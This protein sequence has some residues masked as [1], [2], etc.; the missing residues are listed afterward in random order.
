MRIFVNVEGI[1]K[2]YGNASDDLIAAARALGQV[3]DVSTFTR[4]GIHSTIANLPPGESALLVGG[5]DLIPTFVLTNPTAHVEGAHGD[6][7][8]PSD[9]P[10]GGTPGNGP[11]QLVP[12]RPVARIPDG[13]PTSAGDFLVALR[14]A[15]APKET[16]AGVFQEAALEFGK[17]AADVSAVIDNDGSPVLLSP[18]E[19]N[20]S[21]DLAKRLPGKG[22]LHVLLHGANF[23]S[24]WSDLYGHA[25]NA[26]AWPVALTAQLLLQ[27]KLTGSV[28]TFSSCYAAMIDLDATG[29]AVRDASNQVSLG[30]LGSGAKVSFAATRSNW[31]DKG[32]GDHFGPGLVK[33]VWQGLLA[34][35]NAGQ[36]LID[37]KRQLV[38]TAM[39]SPNG[40]ADL[41]YVYKT[42]LQA[43][44]YGNPDVTL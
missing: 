14:F 10:Y 19:T 8:V 18:P 21:P 22:R 15:G 6:K 39:A 9:A 37:A 4:S 11:Q 31:I 25:P 24:G 12:T 20:T 34:K 33:L 27:A 41:P 5:Y 17:P 38:K 40:R 2:K 1:K 16:P 44:L 7:D 32:S 3:I 29:R 43:Q 26:S 36:A 23:P 28:V 13:P 35:K 30:C 42:V